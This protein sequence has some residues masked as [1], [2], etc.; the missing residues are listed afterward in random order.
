MIGFWQQIWQRPVMPEE[1]SRARK[2]NFTAPAGPQMAQSDSWKLTA[3]ELVAAARK[4]KTESAGPDGWA[5][6]EVQHWPSRAWQIFS[7]LSEK[8]VEVNQVP[9]VWRH[10]RQVMIPKAEGTYGQVKV[11]DMRPIAVQPVM[12]RIISFAF[13]RR[14]SAREW[15]QTIVPDFTHGAVAGRGVATALLPLQE[16]FNDYGI[17]ISLDQA[18]CFD[19]VMPELALGH[20]KHAGMRPQWIKR[21]T[22]TWSH[23]KRWVQF[24][25]VRH[26]KVSTSIPQGCA[27]ALV[28]LEFFNYGSFQNGPS[29][30]SQSH[31]YMVHL[32]HSPGSE[33]EFS[34]TASC[35]QAA[36]SQTNHVIT[37]CAGKILCAFHS[38]SWFRF[39]SRQVCTWSDGPEKE[40]HSSENPFSFASF[41]YDKGLQRI[42]I[43]QVARQSSAGVVG[44]K[45]TTLSLT[46]LGTR[47]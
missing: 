10:S 26:Q 35:M 12:C 27:I 4:K 40:R 13:A 20:L 29:A 24:G 6:A 36:F 18:K 45:V 37:R 44:C 25:R 1:L 3:S 43:E 31:Q 23:Q 47:S 22:W 32:E 46:G 38:N 8:W 19:H 16:T 30:C 34:Q 17:I 41:A 15:L 28:A 7:E 21:F 42:C 2:N 39:C 5:P 9:D 11:T 33:G 14:T